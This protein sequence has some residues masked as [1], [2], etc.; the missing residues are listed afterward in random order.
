MSVIFEDAGFQT[1]ITKEEINRL[2]M[3]RYDGPICYV[4]SKAELEKAIK[5]LAHERLL[6]F[7][8]ESKP[9]FTKGEKH[10]PAL[11]Q[12]A[13]KKVVYLFSLIQLGLPESLCELLANESVIKA[14]VAIDRDV[15][16]LREIADFEPRGFVDIGD[17]ARRMG[18]FNHGLRGM[19]ALLL[20]VHVSK[21]A[22]RS[23]WARPNLTESQITYAATDAWLGR[24][25]Y[26]ALEDRGAKM[27]L[28]E[29]QKKHQ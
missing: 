25:I 15:A 14:G 19:A 17:V 13:G 22:Q 2:P 21:G 4:R 7:D 28:K 5:G 3:W 8:T 10:L 9:T 23:N 24:E 27:S 1:R 6:G 29:G 16:E 11:L 18:L 26:L 20:G 12:I